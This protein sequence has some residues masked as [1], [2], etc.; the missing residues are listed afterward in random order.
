LPG[1]NLLDREWI[2][3]ML[4]NS[5]PPTYLGIRQVLRQ[6]HQIQQIADPAPTV[7]A[8][9]HRLLLAMLHCSL[10]GPRSPAE[11]GAIWRAGTWDM[12]CIEEY[13]SRFHDRFDLFD[14]T[15]PF[16]QTTGL[17]NLQE[18][19]L[20]AHDWASIRNRPLLFDH[21]LP[22]RGMTPEAATRYLIA[23]QGFSVGGMFN[24]EPG[25]GSAAKFAQGS[26]LL[27]S[28]VCLV[29]GKNLFETLMLNWHLYNR[30]A[31]QPFEFRGD[32]KP[33]WERD[34]PVTYSTRRPDGWVDLL[35]WQ[36]R[37]ILLRPETSPDGR[38]M[39]TQAALMQGYRLPDSFDPHISETMVAYS[40]YRNASAG[41]PWLPISLNPNKAIWRDS[42]AL[43][44]S[45]DVDHSRPRTLNWLGTLVAESQL[46]F[47]QNSKAL[48]LKVLGITPDQANIEDWR[49]ETL[50]L[51]QLFLD[52]PELAERATEILRRELEYAEHM[53]HL[54][55]PRL[56]NIPHKD[57]RLK[58]AG[59]SPIRI[60]A[61]ELLSLGERDADS[62][63]VG[64]LGRHISPVINYWAVLEEPF[65]TFLL[66]LADDIY[67]NQ[68]GDLAERGDAARG[69]SEEIDRVTRRCFDEV[70][71]GLAN[72]GRAL[73]A[74]ALARQQFRLFSSRLSQAHTALI[75]KSQEV[76]N[77]SSRAN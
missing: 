52:R 9:L 4:N 57:K 1:F 8:A 55:E 2:P 23:Q 68:F 25:E 77:D 41:N 71:T 69:W 24:T 3:C 15:H 36:C 76:V 73:R 43:F 64:A 7:T 45:F 66:A 51:P 59:P 19:N 18:V 27:K 40:V 30:E 13:L 35:T 53:A 37:R 72:S 29:T 75:P 49:T 12:A 34:E 38:V 74:A 20:I 5:G 61:S 28:A 67:P 58:V 46:R 26:P 14:A 48:P 50:T 63:A 54:L 10:N 17:T 11:W 42:H 65:R 62:K 16:Y 33:A 32:D 22:G 44:Q 39:V 56:L 6:A 31:E 21:S 60:L 70:V 47:A